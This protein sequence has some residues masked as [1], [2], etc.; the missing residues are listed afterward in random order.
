MI[1][2]SKLKFFNFF[3]WALLIRHSVSARNLIHQTSLLNITLL[4]NSSFFVQFVTGIIAKQELNIWNVQTMIKRPHR[5]T[6]ITFWWNW[7]I[8]LSVNNQL[9]KNISRSSMKRWCNVLKLVHYKQQIFITNDNTKK[10]RGDDLFVKKINQYL[11]K[12]STALK[13]D[14]W[15]KKVAKKEQ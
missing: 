15:Y 5:E 13:K 7:I 8:N 10:Q 11:E 1:S 2:R 4:Y 6:F 12:R 9:P 14:R 3:Q